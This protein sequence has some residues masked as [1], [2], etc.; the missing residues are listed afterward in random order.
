[1]DSQGRGVGCSFGFE[2]WMGEGLPSE[3]E[4][5]PENVWGKPGQIVLL[6]HGLFKIWDS[7]TGW[8]EVGVDTLIQLF[9]NSGTNQKQLG[10]LVKY[11]DARSYL[12]H[13]GGSPYLILM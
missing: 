1:M 7:G 8:A 13:T 9:L 3:S 6:S 10:H 5:C 12:Y 4:I 2:G 11:R